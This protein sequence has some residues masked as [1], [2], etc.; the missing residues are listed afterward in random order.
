[1]KPSEMDILEIVSDAG[2]AKN[3]Y[4]EAIQ[5]PKAVIMKHVMI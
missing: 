3:L 1:M 2:Q 5:K 4:I